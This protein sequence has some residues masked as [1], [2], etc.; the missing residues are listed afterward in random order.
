M[1]VCVCV[2]ACVWLRL[3]GWLQIYATI[4]EFIRELEKER[5]RAQ[6]ATWPMAVRLPP[7]SSSCISQRPGDGNG[8]GGPLGTGTGGAHALTHAQVHM[9]RENLS[10]V[11]LEIALRWKNLQSSWS[12]SSQ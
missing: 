8:G 7:S 10:D 6:G 4:E 9:L 5:G 11:L 1:C 2:F 3:N 12:V